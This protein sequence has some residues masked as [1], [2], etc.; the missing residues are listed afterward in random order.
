MPRVEYTKEDEKHLIEYLAVYS[1]DGRN[2][3]GNSLY[4]N[5]EANLDG[6]WPWACRHT[7]S[8][9]R[10]HYK[11]NTYYF[12]SRITR[13][14]KKHKINSN[15]NPPPASRAASVAATPGR[16]QKEPY[17]T[18]DDRNLVFYMAQHSLTSKNRL[19]NKLY[20][21]LW[22]ST[23]E[24]R[25]WVKRHPWKSWRERY[26]NNQAEYDKQIL[27]IQAKLG[28]NQLPKPTSPKR[29]RKS[30]RK[31]KKRPPTPQDQSEAEERPLPVKHEEEEESQVR[32][33]EDR[34]VVSD[35]RDGNSKGKGKQKESR[36]VGEKRTGEKR[37][38]APADD[39][40]QRKRRRLGTDE[41]STTTKASEGEGSAES[42]AS[43]DAQQ[44]EA[45][46]YTEGA[47]AQD[48]VNAGSDH[49]EVLASDDYQGEIF[50]RESE[51]GSTSEE[52][53]E[54]AAQLL[55]AIDERAE[56]DE[57][58]QSQSAGEQE[59]TPTPAHDAAKRNRPSPSIPETEET[60][61]GHIYP[62]VPLSPMPVIESSFPRA[63]LVTSTPHAQADPKQEPV[64]SQITPRSQTPT[65]TAQRSNTKISQEPT[66]PTSVAA[67]SPAPSVDA[68]PEDPA[69]VH[70]LTIVE[71]D[72]STSTAVPHLPP[73]RPRTSRLPA[74]KDKDSNFFASVTS[75]P[76]PAASRHGTP[77]RPM[78]RRE[79]PRFEE[80]AFN[81]VLTD[82]RGK[83]PTALGNRSRATG[84]AE[85][86]AFA[87]DSSSEQSQNEQWPPIRGR[88]RKDKASVAAARPKDN[89][90]E[91]RVFKRERSPDDPVAA[92]KRPRALLQ[93]SHAELD[94]TTNGAHHAFSQPTS[95]A[96]G[97]APKLRL[98]PKVLDEEH[99]HD[100]S[101][102]SI[103]IPSILSRL[104]SVIGEKPSPDPPPVVRKTVPTSKLAI[105][106]K[107]LGRELSPLD[108][109]ARANER[110][111]PT[112]VPR[113]ISSRLPSGP[114]RDPEQGRAS[115]YSLPQAS[116]SAESSVRSHLNR[117]SPTT[118]A[119]GIVQPPSADESD[120]EI[121]DGGLSYISDREHSRKKGKAKETSSAL[122]PAEQFR[123]HLFGR[124]PDVS[125]YHPQAESTVHVRQSLPPFLY[126]SDGGDTVDLR[127]TRSD[128]SL[129]HADVPYSLQAAPPL[130][131]EESVIL[132]GIALQGM[133]NNHGFHVN[134]VSRLWRETES[135]EATD[136]ILAEMREAANRTAHEM[137][138]AH[139]AEARARGARESRRRRRSSGRPSSHHLRATSSRASHL[140][141]SSRDSSVFRYIPLPA[142]HAGSDTVEYSPPKH[143]RAGQYNRLTK[144]GRESEAYARE[145]SRVTGRGSPSVSP[146]KPGADAELDDGSREQVEMLLGD[147]VQDVDM[148]EQAPQTEH[149]P[150]AISRAM[151]HQLEM[152]NGPHSVRLYTGT[153]LG[154][155]LAC[156][157]R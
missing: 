135:M 96:T 151:L 152:Q 41:V 26:K 69:E 126:T 71:D 93:T 123:G 154:E 72:G 51:V 74:R 157:D 89:V 37:A 120:A 7:W 133:S 122:A 142:K 28:P 148:E 5:L 56:E 127:H 31:N 156:N 109:T 155:Y 112:F 54:E 138:E 38:I 70:A 64:P 118:N 129:S 34:T 12:S 2:R 40:G 36:H 68:E 45:S 52:D 143:T 102:P 24:G 78:R 32:E 58:Q 131:E 65:Q 39:E 119:S 117:P 110:Q 128:G 61:T 98:R 1:P 79:P 83:R 137:L 113:E 95:R 49:E 105:L 146:L 80:G 108:V 140:R 81:S 104:T 9:W 42:A 145:L 115:S 149:P 147:E 124:Y 97:T 75:T 87:S 103:A 43:T 106:N 144:E 16:G 92:L 59:A 6:L 15:L 94:V 114:V 29:A 101:Q 33:E 73:R 60:P 132:R 62:D 116:S 50:D 91:A 10:D 14:Q 55:D 48:D 86:D 63:F 100:F 18:E 47:T 27:R 17:T 30:P 82:A 88:Q 121:S 134:V 77:V 136:K 53:D 99:H 139:R 46:R 19:G 150:R 22:S 125:G 23:D 67:Q 13:Y 20:E 153:L 90:Q 8:S 57:E 3:A 84:I 85:E 76:T 11:M 141:D 107:M 66:P 21:D 25:S 4:K 44:P 130:S 111:Q 35:D